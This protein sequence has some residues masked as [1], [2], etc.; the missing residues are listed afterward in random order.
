MY[1]VESSTIGGNF[2]G[3]YTIPRCFETRVLRSTKTTET[4]AV[5]YKSMAFKLLEV[6]VLGDYA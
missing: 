5:S 1:Y 6:G 2:Y 3:T 4:Q